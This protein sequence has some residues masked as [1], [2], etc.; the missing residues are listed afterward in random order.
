MG[1]GNCQTQAMANGQAI[2]PPTSS[3]YSPVVPIKQATCNIATTGNVSIN[4]INTCRSPISSK[5]D[6]LLES[7][8]IDQQV[9]LIPPKMK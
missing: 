5:Y 1:T 4:P 6:Q 2:I 3:Y 9:Q 7:I 8:K